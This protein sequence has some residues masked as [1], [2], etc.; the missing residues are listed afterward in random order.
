MKYEPV[1]QVFKEGP[2][3]HPAKEYQRDPDQ[4]E[5]IPVRAIIQGVANDRQI[6]TPD[7]Q[8]VSLGQH[9]KILVLEKLGLSLIMYLLEFH[10]IRD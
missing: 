7:H 2:E 8:R 9:L 5:F 3:Q 4:R 6:Q 10:P 1:H